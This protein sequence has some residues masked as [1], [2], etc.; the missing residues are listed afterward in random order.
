[1]FQTLQDGLS[2]AFRQLR[3]QA[4][5]SEQNM[6]DGLK[7]VRRS[8]LDADVNVE[9]AETFITRV[10]EKAA[11]REVLKQV[12]PSQQFIHIV[13]EELVNLMGPVDA[14]IRLQKGRPTILMLCGLQGSGKT[15]TCAKLAKLLKSQG[16]HPLMVA[17][18]LQRPAAIEQ[19]QTLGKQLDIPVYAEPPTSN[20]VDVCRNGIK[21]ANQMH[22]NLIILDT[23]GRLAIDQALMDELRTIDKKVMPDQ[24][25][26]VVDG[27]MGQDA[28]ATA[29]AFNDALQLDAVVMTKLDGDA[30]GGAALSVKEI[31]GVP[32]KFVGVGEGIDAL[33]PFRPESMA[34]RILSMPDIIGLVEDISKKIDRDKAEAL[35]KK[36]EAGKFDL[37]DFRQHLS[38]FSG[39]MVKGML[40]K[41]GLGKAMPENVDAD[42]E[43]RR[44]KAMMDSMTLQERKNP[45]L[46]KVASRRRRIA[47]GSGTD[48]SEINKLYK[49]F[50]QMRPVMQQMASLSMMDRMKMMMGL[51]RN[52]MALMNGGNFKPPEIVRDDPAKRAALEKKRKQERQRKKQQRKHKKK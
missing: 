2:E 16:Q 51:A 9:V 33:E 28:V 46:L 22:A 4:R 37:D 25:L 20:P 3:G 13:Y 27:Q 5:L 36:M 12:N 41:M 42:K 18:D 17:A 14:T 24:C 26:L 34:Q 1:M 40:D 8:L 39:G 21:Y 43:L 49:Q 44:F 29:K 6:L 11:G 45:E 50:E 30:R 7:T 15:T 38:M 35:Q 48:P 47:K 52:P 31:T 19:L 10:K 32:I 23:A